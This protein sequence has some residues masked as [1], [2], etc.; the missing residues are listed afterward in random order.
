MLHRDRNGRK[1]FFV[2]NAIIDDMGL[3]GA[4]KLVLV[5]LVYHYDAEWYMSY[6]T[7][8][9]IAEETGLTPTWVTKTLKRLE[10]RGVIRVEREPGY[11]S[12]YF[13]LTPA[14]RP[15]EA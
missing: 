12:Q 9:T 5:S 3:T 14:F 15:R 11:V 7:R 8:Q 1:Y 13:I 6:P 2:P 10:S 4:E